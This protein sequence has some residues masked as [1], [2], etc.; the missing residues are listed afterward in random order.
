[1][2]NWQVHAVILAGGNGDRLW[3]LSRKNNPKQ[4]LPFT[5]DQSLLEQ[6][7]DRIAPLIDQKHRWIMTCQE[8]VEHIEEI[9]GTTVE[10][11]LIE[12]EPR[13][14][15]AAMI[16]A[17]LLL[18]EEH[19]HAT[20]IFLPSDHYI[21][22]KELFLNFIEHAIDYAQQHETITLLGLKPS[23]PATGYGYIAYQQ[24][25]Q[26]PAR[27]TAFYEKPTQAKAQEYVQQG[28]VWNSGICIAQVKTFL[29]ICQETAPEIFEG[30]L[31]FVHGSGDYGLV[32]KESFDYAI[33]EKTNK[34]SVLPI[35]LMWSDVGNL[36]TFLALRT[37]QSEASSVIEIDAKNNI[38]EAENTLVALVGV[39]DLCVVQKDDIV[40][41]VHRDQVEKVKQVIDILKRDHQ[42]EY[43]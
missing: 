42:E 28:Y 17:A 23:Y 2:K 41:V 15:A 19:P 27:V 10:H 21:V 4:L 14:T 43:L 5:K 38:V 12:P 13:N 33:L 11:I 22:Q 6:T 3:P 26:Y 7:I 16:L 29:S 36:E 25:Q 24:E 8:Q 20:I 40:L 9:V 32:K 30:V 31:Q 39:K 1:M 37:T 18:E 35:D 34:V